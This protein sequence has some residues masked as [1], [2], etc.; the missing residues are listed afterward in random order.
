MFRIFGHFLVGKY[1]VWKA[2]W[3]D[4]QQIFLLKKYYFLGGAQISYD[5]IKQWI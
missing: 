2:T 3:P 1:F 5:S 4:F